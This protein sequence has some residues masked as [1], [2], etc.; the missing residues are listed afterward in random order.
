MHRRSFLGRAAAA[1][2][3]LLPPAAFAAE[4][5]RF[6]IPALRKGWEARLRAIAAKGVLPVVDIES[7]YNPGKIDLADF[8]ARMDPLGVAQICMSPQIG[9]KGFEAGKLWNDRAHEAVA[10]FPDHFI[11]T[12]TSAIWPTWTEK[13]DA[14]LDIHF[15]RVLEDGY[16][17]MGEF[18]F[19]HYPSPRELKRGEMYRDIHIPIDSEP[20]HRLFKFSQDTGISFQIHYEIEDVLLAPL[21]K[22]LAAYPKAKVIWCHLAQIRYQKRSTI[23]GPD[24]LRK[25]LEA[26]PGL[27][28]DTAFGGPNAIYPASGE[29]QARVWDATGKR[30]ARM[31]RPHPRPPLAFPGGPGPGRRPHE[32]AR[33]E[34][35][36]QAALPWRP[37]PAGR[38]HGRLPFGLEAA[39]QRRARPVAGGAA[40]RRP[41][42]SPRRARA[43]GTR[44]RAPASGGR[45][46]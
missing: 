1:A 33:G 26:H 7:S 44:A 37:G 30:A 32:R 22:M 6:D 42:A 12:S 13:P 5:K 35:A 8:A 10:A 4:T 11:P 46:P 38:P 41:S 25:L 16:P 2:A 9:K 21:E 3:A 40:T 39:V 17:L 28:I 27:H 34:D 19:R 20:G 23:Y 31:G 43:R 45:R 24:Y 29:H 36:Q 18:E 15:R 14:F